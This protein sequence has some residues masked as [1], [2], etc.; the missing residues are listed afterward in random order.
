MDGDY[1][2]IYNSGFTNYVIA[3]RV[4][5]NFLTA[6]VAGAVLLGVYNPMKEFYL[7][8]DLWLVSWA[9]SL[10]FNAF[11]AAHIVGITWVNNRL[12]VRVYFSEEKNSF[13]VIMSRFLPWKI[14]KL[15]CDCGELSVARASSLDSLYG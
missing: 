4:L 3:S 9:E 13:V 12:P 5:V 14:K 15:D 2:L 1:E 7:G 11:I 10:G 6:G 8:E